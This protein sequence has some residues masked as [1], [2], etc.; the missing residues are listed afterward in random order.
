MRGG[1]CPCSQPWQERVVGR[2]AVFMALCNSVQSSSQHETELEQPEN[3]SGKKSCPG[4]VSQRPARN[5]GPSV[6]KE[7]VRA[8]G[9]GVLVLLCLTP[10]ARTASSGRYWDPGE[11][12]SVSKCT[13]SCAPWR[14]DRTVVPGAFYRGGQARTLVLGSWVGGL[15]PFCS[16]CVT[17][18]SCSASLNM[19]S[20]L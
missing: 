6:P 19:T 14:R 1:L 17:S 7:M 18:T 9:I 13:P 2:R 11:C 3:S 4:C 15:T 8:G 5:P 20:A 10:L 12:I 16:N